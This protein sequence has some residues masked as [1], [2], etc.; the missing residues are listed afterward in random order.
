MSMKETCI[1]IID[2]DPSVREALSLLLRSAG[3]A[4]EAFESAEEFLGRKPFGGIGC[5]VLD[6]RMSGMSGL[7]L[8][9]ELVRRD[10]CMPVVFITGHGDIPM[11]V[12]AIKRGAVDFLPKPFEDE[13]LLEA[14]QLAIERHEQEELRHEEKEGISKRIGTLTAREN[15]VLR[16]AIAGLMNKQIAA[17]LKIAEQTVKIHRSRIMQKLGASS[18]ADLVRMTEKAGIPMA[19]VS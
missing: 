13:Q 19:Q 6:V 5:I 18:V 11:T 14:I 17:E 7:D 2:D 15:E 16:Y 12:Q 3:Y 4:F 8:Q 1:F 9:N 10:R